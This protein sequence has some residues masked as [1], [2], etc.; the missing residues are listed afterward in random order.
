[1]IKIMK[2]YANIH[3]YKNNFAGFLK[4][5]NFVSEDDFERKD[6]REKSN[7]TIKYLYI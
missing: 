6:F 2:S 4:K 3:Y 1:M 5:I 7:G